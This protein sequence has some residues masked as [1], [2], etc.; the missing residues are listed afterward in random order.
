[1][2]IEDFIPRLDKA[3]KA[4]N[5]FIYTLGKRLTQT[6]IE[7]IE[8]RL[9]IKIPLKVKEFYLKTNGLCTVNPDFQVI[10]INSWEVSSSLI[11]FATFNKSFKIYFD[12]SKLNSASEWTILNKEDN[13]EITLTISSFWSNKIWHW[14]EKNRKIWASKWVGT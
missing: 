3:K 4:N 13:Y 2:N 14:I 1:M 7:S 6:D 9:N 11:H 10:E 5:E 12:T 8:N